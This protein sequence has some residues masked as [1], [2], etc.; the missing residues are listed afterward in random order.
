LGQR[1]FL[2]TNLERATPAG[3][4]WTANLPVIAASL[5]LLEQNPL[6]PGDR[7]DGNSVFVL[8]A[9]SNY[10]RAHDHPAILRH[11]PAAKIETIP[12]SG[13]NPH[14]EARVDFVRI[15]LSALTRG[16]GT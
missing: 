10:V 1:K 5:D 11:F 14:M 12:S 8:G 6:G 4:R 9:R 3:W 15:V 2:L 13:H 7:F 16:A